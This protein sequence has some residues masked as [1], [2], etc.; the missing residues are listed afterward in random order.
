LCGLYPP[1]IPS[2]PITICEPEVVGVLDAVE[3]TGGGG[4]ALEHAETAIAIT[5]NND[6]ATA[7][8][9]RTPITSPHLEPVIVP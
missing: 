1:A 5:T 2:T 9:V 7:R 4:G 3:V 8:L 6:K